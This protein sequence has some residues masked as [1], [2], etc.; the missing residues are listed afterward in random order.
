MDNKSRK[1]NILEK[2]A[3]K[4]TK[5]KSRHYFTL[6]SLTYLLALALFF[7]FIVFISSFILFK[8]HFTGLWHLPSFGW[9]GFGSFFVFFPWLLVLLVLLLIV[10]LEIAAKKFS[11]VYKRPLMYSLLG[12]LVFVSAFAFIVSKTP[13]HPLLFQGARQ[14]KFLVVNPLYQDPFLKKPGNTFI[15]K[16]I[17]I[18][19]KGIEVEDEKGKEFKVI[20]S[21]KTIIFFEDDLRKGDLVLIMGKR[22]GS[23]I[24]A[25]GI[26]EIEDEF[27]LYFPHPGSDLK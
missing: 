27:N 13:M 8:I 4:E 26:K 21:P 2:I 19:G 24:E 20:V 1:E 18:T 6:K 10:V 11:L 9:K 15:G 7:I 25:I 5:M 3:K 16:V 22:Q 23:S 17:D 12:I 14:G